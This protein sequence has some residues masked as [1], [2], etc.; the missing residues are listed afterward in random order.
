MSA[1]LRRDLR[2]IST[3]YNLLSLLAEKGSFQDGWYE[4]ANEIYEK[5]NNVPYKFSNKHD[6]LI[7]GDN[8]KNIIVRLLTREHVPLKTIKCNLK[9]SDDEGYSIKFEPKY[10]TF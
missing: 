3:D 10:D 4:C 6:A 1:E 2:P 7:F 5:L 8:M 9:G